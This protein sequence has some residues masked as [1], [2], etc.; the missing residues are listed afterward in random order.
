MI[1]RGG[2]ARSAEREVGPSVTVP[3][4]EAQ[5]CAPVVVVSDHYD[6]PLH[7]LLSEKR[8]LANHIKRTEEE[9]CG[10]AHTYGTVLDHFFRISTR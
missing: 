1:E 10:K 9:R 7:R 4:V 2:H 5:T 3:V 6:A 8:S